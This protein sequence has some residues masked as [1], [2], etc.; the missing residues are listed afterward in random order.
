LLFN[1]H[2]ILFSGFVLEQN[3]RTIQSLYG[4]DQVENVYTQ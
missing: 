4:I 3:Y 1:V 2:Y